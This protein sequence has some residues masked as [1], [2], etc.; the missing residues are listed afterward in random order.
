MSRS[1]PGFPDVSA[2]ISV[3]S[4]SSGTGDANNG[5]GGEHNSDTDSD[6]DSEDKADE[7]QAELN[8]ISSD[9]ELKTKLI[10]QLE[11]S[12]QRMQVMRQ[13]Y[14]EK[15]NLL[16]ARI[17]STQK[18]R[19]QVLAN[20]SASGGTA[21]AP[22]NDKIKKVREEY[23]RKLSDMQRELRKLQNAQKEHIR[24]QREL[25]AQDS[26]LRN[27]KNELFELKSAKIRLMR[28]MNEDNNRHKEEEKCRNREISKLRKE[29]R[30]QLNTIKSL[31]AQGAAKDQIL[32]RRTEQVTALRKGQRSHLSV[33]AAGRVPIKADTPPTFSVRQARIKWETV[34]RTIN[35]AA[36]SKQAIVELER[37]LERL[38]LERESLSK[39]LSNVKKRQKMQTASSSDLAYDEDTLTANLNYIQENISHIQHSIMELDEGKETTSEPQAIRNVV[40]DVDTLEEAKF[41]LEKLC[42]TAIV[43]TCDIALKQTRLLERDAILNEVQQDS[44]MQQQILQHVLAQNPAL[45]DNFGTGANLSG[46]G[47]IMT[48]TWTMSTIPSDPMANEFDS[49]TDGCKALQSLISSRSTSPTPYHDS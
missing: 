40:E 10:E 45:S 31:Q 12:Q 1:L 5:N 38:L 18:E 17:V 21:A 6:S 30:K 3:V 13:H 24:Q 8:D 22:G 7:M 35:K 14:E 25:Q 37:E 16:N 39:D 46:G 4:S 20:M 19:D 36:R 9:I 42:S 47:S 34:L 33:K 41:L 15:L 43:Q 27:L 23:E 28:K 48:N 32:K 11:L 49:I 2:S 29:S 26:Q 44:T